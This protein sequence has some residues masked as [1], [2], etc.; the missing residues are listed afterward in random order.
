MFVKKRKTFSIHAPATAEIMYFMAFILSVAEGSVFVL[1]N[2]PFL[3][4]GFSIGGL[5]QGFMTI[6]LNLVCSTALMCFKY[7]RQIEVHE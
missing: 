7:G 6:G 2:I 3:F 1:N 4:F 5:S